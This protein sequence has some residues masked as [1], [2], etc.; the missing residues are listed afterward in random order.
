MHQFR[1]RAL[2][3]ALWG[4]ALFAA[5]CDLPVEPGSDLPGDVAAANLGDAIDTGANV[6]AAPN[7]DISGRFNLQTEATS[8]YSSE[9]IPLTLVAIA[10]QNG[11]LESGS[12][13]VSLELRPPTAPDQM[14]ASTPQPTPISSNGAFQVAVDGYTVSQQSFPMLEADTNAEVNLDAQIINSNCFR[15]DTTMTLRD[16]QV[17]GTTVPKLVLQGPFEAIRQGESCSAQ[18]PK[19]DVGFD[20]G[21]PDTSDL[22]A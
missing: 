20:A 11:D 15:G 17:S 19:N 10:D 2:L 12:A 3:P 13:T 22:G 14:G 5:G 16:V 4:A 1:P 6:T 21:R 7:S 9:P 8:Q 18:T